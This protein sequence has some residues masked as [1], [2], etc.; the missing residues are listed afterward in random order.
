MTG[1][2]TDSGGGVVSD[3][4]IE[5]PVTPP[6]MKW[7]DSRKPFRPIAAE[8]NPAMIRSVF[9]I[10][11]CIDRIRNQSYVSPRSRSAPARRRRPR[12]RGLAAAQVVP[13]H[14]AVEH[15]VELGVVLPAVDRVVG[16]EDDPSLAGVAARH[17]DGERTVGDLVG[18]EN[19]DAQRVVVT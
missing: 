8:N 7:L 11:R 16:E 19:P 15:H 3:S 12:R 17:L 9:M 1:S 6:S 13:V 10:A 4:S 5:M 2:H 14:D 18:A